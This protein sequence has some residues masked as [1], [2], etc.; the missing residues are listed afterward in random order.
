[1]TKNKISNERNARR[2]ARRMARP[3]TGLNAQPVARPT[4]RP[5]SRPGVSTVV[6]LIMVAVIGFF[7]LLISINVIDQIRQSSA[8]NKAN[9]VYYAAEGALEKGLLTN[10][11]QGAGYN[12]SGNQT[13]LF[14]EDP[15]CLG[16]A[17]QTD[18][19]TCCDTNY[20]GN[21]NSDINTECK[22]ACKEF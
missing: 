6:T 10:L 21:T 17:N 9:V 22:K 11:S 19:N 4:S 8:V 2:M 1:M 18:C 3:T 5:T 15:E 12:T 13:V 20:P 16:K 14:N 7:A